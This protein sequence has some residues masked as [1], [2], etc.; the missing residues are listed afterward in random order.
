MV[1]PMATVTM[2]IWPSMWQRVVEA[3]HAAVRAGWAEPTVFATGIGP[4]YPMT[5]GAALLCV[6]KSAGPLASKVG[7]SFNQATSHRAY[8]DWMIQRQ[9]RRSAFW[10]AMEKIDPT[11]PSLAWTNVCKMDRRG[12][13]RPPSGQEWAQV[14]APCIDAL[15]EEILLVEPRVNLFA[16]SDAHRSDVL[17]LLAD[18]GYVRQA[19]SFDDGWTSLHRAPDGGAAIMTRHPQGWPGRTGNECCRWSGK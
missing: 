14:A 13:I 9:N 16:T 19:L 3:N 5:P 1:A 6:G 7:S 2:P 17:R 18:L 15:R 4:D 10:Q 11:R 12:G 8:T